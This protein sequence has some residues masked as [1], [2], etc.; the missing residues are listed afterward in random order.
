MREIFNDQDY[1]IIK[2]TID[3][4]FSQEI[5]SKD[6]AVKMMSYI[7]MLPEDKKEYAEFYF[8][9]QLEELR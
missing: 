6:F 2:K 4:F 8:K 5:D 3:L 9:L 7:K 1:S